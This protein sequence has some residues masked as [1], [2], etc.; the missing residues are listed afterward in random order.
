MR[1]VGVRALDHLFAR[2]GPAPVAVEIDQP[3]TTAP[4]AVALAGH[5]RDVGGAARNQGGIVTPSSSLTP[6]MLSPSAPAVG[7]PSGSASGGTVP[8]VAAPALEDQVPRPVMD[9]QRGVCGSIDAVRGIA[10][11]QR[12]LLDHERVQVSHPAPRGHGHSANADGSRRVDADAGDGV[13]RV[14]HD[15]AVQRD[16]NAERRRGDARLPVRILAERTTLLRVCPCCP[17]LG[18]RKLTPAGP[19]VT[20]KALP[21]TTSAPVVPSPCGGPWPPRAS[22]WMFATALVA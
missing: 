12:R 3:S 4:A 16:A 11:V 5:E 1:P 8:R 9:Q 20:T 6:L 18:P 7:W 14:V 2:V 21:E 10:E 17:L 19:A 15:Q 22:I 13:S